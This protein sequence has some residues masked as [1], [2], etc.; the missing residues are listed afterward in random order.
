MRVLILLAMVVA[1]VPAL[2][3]HADDVAFVEATSEL[4]EGKPATQAYNA[5]DGNRGS[6]W[7]ASKSDDKPALAFGFDA[8]TLV[9]H[10]G[11]V[12]GA[13]KSDA[14]DKDNKRA[15]IIV[16]N[17][18]QVRRE[19]R[20]KDDATL[21]S[22]EL[23][24]PAKGNRVVVEFP[25]TYAG[26]EPDAP[27]CVAEV[28]LRTHAN[29]LVGTQMAAKLRALNT[30]SKRLLHEWVDDVSAPTRTLLFNADGSFT[31]SF[32]PLMEGKPVKLKGRWTA[33]D[34]ALTLDVNGK[35]FHIQT[36]LTNVD[37][38]GQHAVELAVEGESPDASMIGQYRPAPLK[39]P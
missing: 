27:L 18:G 19:I 32:V 16:V 12:V 21:Q 20:L 38:G 29:V 10:I 39:L 7:C 26:K 33:I 35:T 31:Y 6:A 28:Q 36:R 8:P 15:R 3:V 4:D 17:D 30:P 1:L 2:P 14:I 5:V 11:I 13:V 23:N 9:T 37:D 22:F 34:H 24:P 25:Y